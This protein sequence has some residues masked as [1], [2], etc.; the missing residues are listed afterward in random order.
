M[1]KVVV[2][3]VLEFLPWR[4]GS[5]V[6]ACVFVTLCVTDWVPN[7]EKKYGGKCQTEERNK[8]IIMAENSKGS[9]E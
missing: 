2:F 6:V 4:D 8:G 3:V 9:V 7:A 5:N 1:I